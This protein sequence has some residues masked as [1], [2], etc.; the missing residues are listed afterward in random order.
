MQTHGFTGAS[1]Q[2][3]GFVGAC[4][5]VSRSLNDRAT[6]EGN[7]T[8]GKVCIESAPAYIG[9][10]AM[11][12]PE[13][14]FLASNHFYHLSTGGTVRDL[15]K[16][17]VRYVNYLQLLRYCLTMKQRSFE[18][19]LLSSSTDNNLIREDSKVALL[20]S[21]L[22]DTLVTSTPLGVFD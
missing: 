15:G 19:T 16:T 6:E 1:F 17:F 8:V 5:P 3:E 12:L 22:G 11:L 10:H 7:N 9:E 14:A 20:P 18:G 21:G 4:P 2:I 13:V